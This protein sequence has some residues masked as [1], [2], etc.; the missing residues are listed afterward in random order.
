MNDT[1]KT[2]SL[3][4]VSSFILVIKRFVLLARKPYKTM[5]TISTDSDTSQIGIIILF[6]FIYFMTADLV[7]PFVYPPFIL[8]LLVVIHIFATA[9]FF[10]GVSLPLGSKQREI[11][12][13]IMTFTYAIAPTLMWFS[14]TLF[15]FVIL[16]PPRQDSINGNLFTIVFYTFSISMLLWKIILMYF[17]IRFSTHL[18]VSRIVY[19]FILY[20]MIVAPYSLLVY[21]FK[22]F[23][24]PF[25]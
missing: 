13:Y 19:I 20:M 4:V 2:F 7:R 9:L 3:Q 1:I 25:L 23:R 16:P 22:L 17:A 6:I 18:K 24:V 15:L 14:V 10:Y 8:F 21:H 12:R 11:Q 5:R